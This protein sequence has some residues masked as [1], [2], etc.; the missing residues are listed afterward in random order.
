[1]TKRAAID[2]RLLSPKVRIWAKVIGIEKVLIITEAKGGSRL[3]CPTPACVEGTELAQL[4]GVDDARRF[5]EAFHRSGHNNYL[6][7]PKID[8]AARQV[9]D[10][11][12]VA[13]KDEDG[14]TFDQIAPMVGLSRRWVIEIYQRMSRPSKQAELSF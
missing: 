7:V 12:I 9:R 1:M 4:I 3:W 14:Y 8:G 2:I 13:L 6:E 10:A 5:A 11:R